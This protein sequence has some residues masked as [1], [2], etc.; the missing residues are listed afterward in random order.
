MFINYNYID[1]ITQYS[2][3]MKKYA[4]D[5]NLTYKQAMKEG[6]DDYYQWKVKKE[7]AVNEELIEEIET[8]T[9]IEFVLE[10]KRKPKRK[11]QQ[12]A[13]KKKKK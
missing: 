2:E 5:N 9:E 4:Q 6:K 12:K 8:E 13:S 10:P 7:E 3:F 1:H 11:Q